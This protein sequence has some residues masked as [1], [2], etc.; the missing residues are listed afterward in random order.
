MGVHFLSI[1]RLLTT[2][3]ARRWQCEERRRRKAAWRPLMRQHSLH[4]YNPRAIAVSQTVENRAVIN[5]VRFLLVV[6]VCRRSGHGYET[7]KTRFSNRKLFHQQDRLSSQGDVMPFLADRVSRHALQT[8]ML[9]LT[10]L[11][12][13]AATSALIGINGLSETHR[14]WGSAGSESDDF[15]TTKTSYDISSSHGPVGFRA[16]GSSIGPDG[17]IEQSIAESNSGFFSVD[18][19]AQRW[20]GFAYAKSRYTFS[21]EFDS[22][23]IDV[24]AY[25]SSTHQDVDMHLALTDITEN[26][27]MYIQKFSWIQSE[28]TMSWSINYEIMFDVN[29][30]NMYALDLYVGSWGGDSVETSQLSARPSSVSVS[31]P[32]TIGLLLGAILVLLYMRT[33][34]RLPVSNASRATSSADRKND[35]EHL[36][37]LKKAL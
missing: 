15:G 36:L 2:R 13:V 18:T 9:C 20:E 22:M 28:D 21:T 24:G 6:P 4:F 10:C 32:G 29:R 1:R 23:T 11:F 14:I 35:M 17:G 12:P 27:A 5:L 33:R 3:K 31:E 7:S 37:V 16:E 25:N 26:R 30:L 34:R 19:H 8:I